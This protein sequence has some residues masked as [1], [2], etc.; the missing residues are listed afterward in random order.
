MSCSSTRTRPGRGAPST[1]KI[2]QTRSGTY[3]Q[4]VS[5]R[6]PP[7]AR[8]GTHHRWSQCTVF[9]RRRPSAVPAH[10]AHSQNPDSRQPCLGQGG[11]TSPS[12]GTFARRVSGSHEMAREKKRSGPGV[13]RRPS[14]YHGLVEAGIRGALARSVGVLPVVLTVARSASVVDTERQERA[15]EFRASARADAF[16]AS[17][18]PASVCAVAE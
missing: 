11:D 7:L 5:C 9:L 3:G 8:L 18:S 10:P 16:G 17:E 1:L 14:D 15:S 2:W 4:G 13:C 6:Q 12:W